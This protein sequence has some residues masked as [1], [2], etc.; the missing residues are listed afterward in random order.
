VHPLS[1]TQLLPPE[2][3]AYKINLSLV[4]RYPNLLGFSYVSDKTF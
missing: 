2:E 4:F 3:Y 1:S